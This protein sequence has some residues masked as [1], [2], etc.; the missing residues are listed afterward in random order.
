MIIP[1]P[2]IGEE[3]GTMILNNNLLYQDKYAIHV[4]EENDTIF[5]YFDYDVRSAKINMEFQ[6]FHSFYE[7]CIFLCPNAVHFIEGIPYEVQAFDIV[8]IGPNRLHKTQ[9]PSGRPCKR[10]IIQF[11]IP[12][13]ISGLS[14]EYEQ[15][16][17]IFTQKTP[18]FRFDSEL[19]KRLCAKLN[20]IY[21]LAPK[22]DPMRNLI[23]HQKFIEFLILLY[24]NQG[25]NIY[26]NETELSELEQKIYSVAGYIHSHYPDNLTLD[27]LARTH[28]L[29]PSYLSHRFKEV[30]GFSITD[31]IQMTRVRNVQ[32]LLINTN[33]PITEISAPCGF[34]SFS[35]FNRV[36][37]KYIGV[38]PSIYRKQHQI[39]H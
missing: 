13:H 25:S 5:Y 20:D 9:Y 35:Q 30:T 22:T 8:G 4:N 1:G 17:S 27:F 23:I 10:L 38:A 6:H 28:D 12:S 11:N 39:Q 14:N 32:A 2:R 24:L 21:Q 34:N 33:T 18:I 36:F 15:L 3:A 29:S 16:V 31:Y 37:R 7:L 26:A 19:Q